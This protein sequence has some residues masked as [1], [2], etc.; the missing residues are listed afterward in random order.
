MECYIKIDLFYQVKRWS[1]DGQEY[2]RMLKGWVKNEIIK[3]KTYSLTNLRLPHKPMFSPLIITIPFTPGM[4]F[5]AS[6]AF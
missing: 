1:N 4:F 6:M 5:P 2:S 3:N